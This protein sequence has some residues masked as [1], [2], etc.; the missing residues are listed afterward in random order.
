MY[1]SCYPPS[2]ISFY[3]KNASY[4]SM[5]VLYFIYDTKL[6]LSLVGPM[7]IWLKKK[8][9]PKTPFQGVCI[10]RH[11]LKSVLVMGCKH[12]VQLSLGVIKET[13]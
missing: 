6:T 9:K 12:C 3:S 13:L 11:S 10:A 7:N 8:N 2:K 5:L 4:L 1:I